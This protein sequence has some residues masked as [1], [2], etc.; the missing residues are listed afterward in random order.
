MPRNT[1]MSLIVLAYAALVWQPATA[2]EV[3]QGVVGVIAGNLDGTSM[4]AA[5]DLATVLDDGNAL[6]VL[7]IQ[8]KGSVQAITDLLYLRGI[9][10]AIVQRDALEYSL[11]AGLH[12]NLENRIR[13][14]SKLFD[15]EIHLAAGR[16]IGS[17]AELAG[18]TVNIGPPG[19][20]TDL[21]A[22]LILDALGVEVEIARDHHR[23]ALQKLGAG[24]I[25][26]M[27][28][29]GGKPTPL[30][31]SIKA[32]DDL[33]LLP[34]DYTPE[35]LE[36]YLPASFDD[37]DYA[38]LMAPGEKIDTLSVEAILAVYNWADDTS[39]YRRVAR[40]FD[41]FFG[42][43]G[44][45]QQPPQHPKWQDVSL[46]AELPGWRRFAPAQ[47]L[48]AT[49][50]IVAQN[51]PF[52][53]Q[54]DLYLQE[55]NLS[56]VPDQLKRE[57]FA[58]FRRWQGDQSWTFALVPKVVNNAFFTEGYNGCKQAESELNDVQCLY[59]GPG[60]HLEQEQAQI[61]QELVDSD[62]D[63]IAVAPTSSPLIA[64]VLRR[65]REAGIPVITWDSDLEDKDKDLRLPIWA[66][67][68][69]G[70][71]SRSPRRPSACGPAAAR[72]A[73]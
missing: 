56:N 57:L 6:R 43:L 33:H 25:S 12:R 72:S 55:R 73:C 71:A 41:A 28:Y 67:T 7:P 38:G 51:D 47:E 44:E 15:E 27:F 31:Q 63:G 54:F 66:P 52:R 69:I 50:A 18:K 24:E 59:I 22:S 70:S 45:L 3:N 35:L 23:L 34:I 36:L 49:G 61:L 14:V 58:D 62:I 48:L 42:H 39:R 16:D 32:S 17:I 2:D 46:E 53:S 1:L 65:A 26:A 30:L 20:G 5:S 13:Y 21:S 60:E 4:L 10:L 9:D 8:G 19:S 29:V 40:F 68:I 11:R 64:G 37:S